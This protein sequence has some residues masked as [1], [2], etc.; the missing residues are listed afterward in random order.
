MLC[1]LTAYIYIYIYIGL[2]S[3]N[4]VQRK[5]KGSL[6]YGPKSRLLYLKVL[7]VRANYEQKAGNM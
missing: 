5:P 4:H 2:I 3:R 6:I 7:Y 1:V